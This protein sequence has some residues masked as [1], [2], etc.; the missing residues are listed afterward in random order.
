LLGRC[1]L[2]WDKRN[3]CRKRGLSFSFLYL[4]FY[5]HFIYRY[6]ILPRLQYSTFMEILGNLIMQRGDSQIELFRPCKR[7]AV[8]EGSTSSGKRHERAD[9]V[10]DTRRGDSIRDC[11]VAKCFLGERLN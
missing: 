2:N 8:C 3:A 6:E 5:V 10:C 1:M 11:S 7:R 9:T 4:Y